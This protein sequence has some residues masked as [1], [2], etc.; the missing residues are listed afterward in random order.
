MLDAFAAKD[1]QHLGD[2]GGAR[3]QRRIQNPCEARQ[4]RADGGITLDFALDLFER[5]LGS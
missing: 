2:G 5:H 1:G 3:I 4:T